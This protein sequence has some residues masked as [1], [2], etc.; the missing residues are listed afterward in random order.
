MALCLLCS[1]AAP[2]EQT[3]TETQVAAAI[4]H[5]VKRGLPSRRIQPFPA[6]L[7][8]IPVEELSYGIAAAS[9]AYEI[10]PFFLTAMAYREGGFDNSAV[11]KLGELSTFQMAPETVKRA[12]VLDP[13]CKADIPSGA[14][15]CSAAWLSYWKDNLGSLKKAFVM[16]ATGKA[17]PKYL[18]KRIAWMFDDRMT[19]AAELEKLYGPQSGPR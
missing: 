7:K 5:I 18:S 11:G 2:T 9:E 1:A 14:A 8:S 15:W 13:R 10:D 12:Q 4:R 17:S 3:D 19:I 16:Y 6:R